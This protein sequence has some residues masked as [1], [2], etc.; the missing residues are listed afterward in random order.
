VPSLLRLLLLL[1][2]AAWAVENSGEFFRVFRLVVKEGGCRGSSTSNYLHCSD[3][4]LYG[5]LL[6]E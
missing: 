6:E 1:A 3:I 2:T 4:E 5:G